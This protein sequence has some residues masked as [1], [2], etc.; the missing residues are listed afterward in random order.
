MAELEPV[1]RRS[2]PDAVFEQ[3]R[4]RIVSGRF[5]PGDR[6][7]AERTLCESFGVNRGAVREA[8]KRL[9]Q[10]RLVAVRHGGSS[11]VLDYRDAAGLDLIPELLARPEALDD[12]ALLVEVVAGVMEMRSALAPDVA[13]LAALRGDAEL[14]LALDPLV[15]AMREAARPEAGPD[16]PAL[17]RL[18]LAFW[19]ALVRAC[20]N[21][22][23]R[24]AFNSLRAAYERSMALLTDVLAEELRDVDRYARIAVAV[25]SGDADEAESEARHLVRRGEARVKKALAGRG[26]AL[27]RGAE[28]DR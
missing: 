20:G 18:A 22:P 5:A 16:G 1:Q 24:L 25:A 6:L 26:A 28:E 12:P 2:L 23:Y 15:A 19:S 7:P 8:L 13:R 10:A 3:L 4:D 17:Q 9:V 27:G 14:A 11:E 21:L